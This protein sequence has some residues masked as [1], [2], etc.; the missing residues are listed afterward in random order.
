MPLRCQ[1]VTKVH[2]F[3]PE[4]SLQGNYYSYFT[5][6]AETGY[7]NCPGS[8]TEHFSETG[9]LPKAGALKIGF[10]Y[11]ASL[12][13]YPESSAQ[14]LSTQASASPLQRIQRWKLGGPGTNRLCACDWLGVQWAFDDCRKNTQHSSSWHGAFL[15]VTKV[16]GASRCLWGRVMRQKGLVHQDWKEVRKWPWHSLSEDTVNSVFAH[17]IPPSRASRLLARRSWKQVRGL[18]SREMAVGNWNM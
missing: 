6:E 17:S 18:I 8:N 5:G 1:R 10:P 7:L 4:T 13:S 3:T 14:L 2:S 12:C 15:L 16:N 9:F 11:S